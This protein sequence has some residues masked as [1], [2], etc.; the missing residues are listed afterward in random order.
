MTSIDLISQRNKLRKEIRTLLT[1]KHV[2]PQFKNWVLERIT[3]IQQDNTSLKF[4]LRH[5]ED[6][7]L[8]ANDAQKAIQPTLPSTDSSSGQLDL[9]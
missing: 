3:M 6:H 2:H 4:L 7:V 1:H 8:A 5:V 9:F